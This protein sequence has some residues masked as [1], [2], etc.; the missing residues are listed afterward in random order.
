MKDD[1]L[2]TRIKRLESSRDVM[3]ITLMFN[4]LITIVIS[5]YLVG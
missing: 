5:M 2:E 3:G 4:I 1:S